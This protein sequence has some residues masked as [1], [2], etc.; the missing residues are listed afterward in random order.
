MWGPATGPQLPCSPRVAR[1]WS[2]DGAG[3]PMGME[4]PQHGPGAAHHSGPVPPSTPTGALHPAVPLALPLLK[5][6]HCA[7]RKEKGKKRSGQGKR[8]RFSRFQNFV[9]LGLRRGSPGWEP[10]Q[11]QSRGQAGSRG[12]DI[13][14]SLPELPQTSRREDGSFCGLKTNGD[15]VVGTGRGAAKQPHRWHKL[16]MEQ[17]PPLSPHCPCWSPQGPVPCP[18]CQAVPPKRFPLLRAG[19]SKQQENQGHRADRRCCQTPKMTSP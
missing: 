8:G 11:R 16:R 4:Q 18:P 14:T 7:A 10:G 17:V 3:S 2:T 6:R 19:T 1:P 13:H 15:V 9:L 12:G 5:S